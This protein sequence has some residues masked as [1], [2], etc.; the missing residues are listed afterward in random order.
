MFFD[1]RRKIMR[2]VILGNEIKVRNRSGA[3]GGQKG[4]PARLQM[5]VGGSP[6]RR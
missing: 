5:G 6:A 4:V 1:I 2:P 3:D